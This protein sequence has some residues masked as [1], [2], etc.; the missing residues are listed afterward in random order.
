MQILFQFGSFSS[1][2]TTL[3]ADALK[4][5]A[6]GLLAFAVVETVTRAF[7]AMHDTRT[8]VIA[9]L[10]TIGTNI[11]LSWY[12][13]P[14]LGHG[15]LALSISITTTL[16][17]LILLAVL[18]RRTGNFETALFAQTGKMLLAG[19]VLYA[20]ARLLAPPLARAT[21][22]VHGHDLMMYAAFAFT[23][24]SVTVSYLVAAYYLKITALQQL[25]R[26]V[27]AQMTRF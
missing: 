5:F 21:D 11:A 26:R 10:I 27:R 20:S 8:P 4:Y 13:A 22:P 6:F 7:Y 17:M 23:L 3:V 25:M 16:E 1:N 15:G 14:R 12:L 19:V 2:S 18:I 9:S 24:G